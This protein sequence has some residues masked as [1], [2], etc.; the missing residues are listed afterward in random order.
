MIP[1]SILVG[2]TVL[3]GLISM[4]LVFKCKH[5]WEFVDKTELPSRVEEAVKNSIKLGN[6]WT[7]QI[8]DMLEKKVVIVLRCPKCGKAKILRESN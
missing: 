3:F 4:Y 5:S 1:M 6:F 8:Q 2:A 7:S